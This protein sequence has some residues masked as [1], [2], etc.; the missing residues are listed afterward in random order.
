MEGEPPGFQCLFQGFF[1][2]FVLQFG[3]HSTV[4]ICVVF[5]VIICFHFVYLGMVYTQ[6]M[7]TLV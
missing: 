7:E 3:Y 4:M 5:G 2:Y 6:G 1:V